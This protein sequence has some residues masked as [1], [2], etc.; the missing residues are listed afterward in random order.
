MVS[1]NF[2]DI[3][4]GAVGFEE[5]C[6]QLAHAETD[7]GKFV[8]T[9]NPDAGV[10]CYRALDSGEH[11]W[12]AKYFLTT[13]NASQWQQIDKSVNAAL[14]GHPHLTRY[15]V[16]VPVD[17]PDGRSPKGKS[18]R[19]RWNDRVK[20]WQAKAQA[21]GLNVEFEWWGNHELTTR[22]LRPENAGLV[23]HWFDKFI[24]SDDWFKSQIEDAINTAE[25]R[26]SPELHVAGN[27]PAAQDL[28]TFARSE[29]V[30]T[31]VK[32][33]AIELRQA[34]LRSAEYKSLIP[35]VDLG[36]QFTDIDAAV[37]TILRKLSDLQ[38]DPSGDNPFADIGEAL[39][40]AVSIAD[41]IAGEL[42]P[43]SHLKKER[44]EPR[45]D[46]E[47]AYDSAYF[48]FRSFHGQL[49]DIKENLARAVRLTSN[50]LLIMT[51]NAGVG[52]THLLCDFAARHHKR[53]APVV[54]LI[55]QKFTSPDDPMRQM[56]AHIDYPQGGNFHEFIGTLESAAQAA[57]HRALIIIDAINEGQGPAIW[58]P[59][60]T[61]LRKR[62][63]ASKWIG[64]VLSIRSDCE[65]AIIPKNVLSR[66]ATTTHRGFEGIEFDAVKSFCEYYDL[67]L[68]SM[69]ILQPEF[70]NPLWLKIVCQGLHNS[71]EKR[72]P[73]GTLG[74][75][76]PLNQF[77][78]S[79]NARLAKRD[80]LDYHP[81]N[82]LVKRA[83]DILAERMAAD[84][85]MWLDSQDAQDLM[86]PLLPN[87]K[88]SESLYHRMVTE[89]VITE[90]QIKT[91]S[92]EQTKVHFTYERIGEHLVVGHLLGKYDA[93]QLPGA[94]QPGGELSRHQYIAAL[95]IQIPELFGEELLDI[96]PNWNKLF[97]P[98]EAFSESLIWRDPSAV[99]DRT[100]SIVRHYATWPRSYWGNETLDALLSIAL[101][102]RHPLNAHYLDGLL[103]EADMP[104][105]DAWWS[106]HLHNSWGS[107]GPLDKL[108]AWALSVVPDD[109]IS[110]E[111][112]SMA[113]IT[114]A[115]T[116]TSSNR[117]VR[118]NAT[119]GLVNLLRGRPA[120]AEELIN[121]FADVDDP[122]VLER[123]YAVAYGIAMLSRDRDGVGGLASNVYR[124]V[125]ANG[126]P[127]AH[128][129]L[130]DYARDVVERAVHLGADLGVDLALARPPY[131]SEW[132]DIPTEDAIASLTA[133]MASTQASNAADNRAWDAIRFSVEH[134]D[135][136]RYIIGTNSG[137][138]SSDWLTRALDEEPWLSFQE[139]KEAFLAGLSQAELAVI[140]SYEAALLAAPIS[141][142]FT[143]VDDNSDL[144][145]SA[146]P[147]SAVE[148]NEVTKAR[149][150][151]YATLS[152]QHL[153]E[154]KAL[155]ESPA[156]LD[157]RIVQRYILNRV[158]SL[159]WCSEAFGEFD[160]MQRLT[161][162]RSAHKAERLGKKYQWIAYHEI[163]AYIADRYQHCPRGEGTQRYEGAWQLPG[164]RDIDPSVTFPRGNRKA[165][166]PDEP[167]STQWALSEY[168][169]WQPQLP[170]ECWIADHKDI[171][172][173]SKGLVI[174]DSEN[175]NARWLNVYCFQSRLQPH[176]P[177]EGKYDRVRREIWTRAI[178][179]LIPQG[180][181]D[182]F[183]EWVLSG[184]YRQDN[185]HFP[186]REVHRVFVGEHGWGPAPE[187]EEVGY[188]EYT[189]Q[190]RYPPESDPVAAYPITTIVATAISDYD[191]S[192]ERDEAKTL[193]LPTHAIIRDCRLSWTGTGAQY[194][195]ANGALAAYN[196]SEFE[197]GASALLI[198]ADI[199]EEYAASRNLVLCWAVL[200]EKQTLGTLGQPHGWLSMQGAYALRA[201]KPI[202]KQGL[203]HNPP[204][205]EPPR[206]Q[207]ENPVPPSDSAEI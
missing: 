142:V 91:Q 125:F 29:S 2:N 18:A 43:P 153:A 117:F 68:P 176:P 200:G 144:S 7:D 25:P 136:A 50:N 57:N 19:D 33:Y 63:S 129:L 110:E 42:S 54:L 102:E 101:V 4:D 155:D 154:W 9:G 83:V 105:R 189:E 193:Y 5:L 82:N 190:W 162:T 187:Q 93:E 96:A 126:A 65:N 67:Q 150:D 3:R 62:V 56:L 149:D 178:A 180:T 113:T 165:A 168:D 203:I 173:L 76:E 120:S 111:A 48:R 170:T 103:R 66:A 207:W 46:A 137:R 194:V 167:T 80:A 175:P 172:E 23:R 160:A 16:C 94:L 138:D 79:V 99:T 104:S 8:R 132:P 184:E 135:F 12:Q 108:I 161:Y 10:D 128:I 44:R 30:T 181:E 34:R 17:L 127:P 139:R 35:D 123:I 201:G 121:R 204:S 158:V 116:L 87:R 146:D 179:C 53:G 159:G 141:I 147:F 85:A 75:T 112:M 41:K 205:P 177:D 31:D 166:Y 55:G 124:R 152:A 28:E 122:Y 81:G 24:F 192:V 61:D 78:K 140:K 133:K 27:V 114:L 86:E 92:D 188:R 130:R 88:F 47:R 163:M 134:W 195:D 182:A 51:G 151:V 109:S 77:I 206:G 100:E 95:S 38:H 36:N 58:Q 186:V 185:Y 26:Y 191:C 157:L 6:A 1:I 202:G 37:E 196:P 107:G 59:H 70:S 14:D 45:A 106:T 40:E 174:I 52:K 84:N 197:T 171:P 143:E 20:K 164:V 98:I 89:G 74:I 145:Q 72:L 71:G 156:R 39:G 118:D 169:N 199:L 198:R 115:W 90:T 11:G 119:K 60:L 131:Q 15:V 97:N 73:S 13:P 32:A 49:K 64:L 22:L 183:S 69:P 21:R 148:E